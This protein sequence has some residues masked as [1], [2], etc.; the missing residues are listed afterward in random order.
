MR[1]SRAAEIYHGQREAPLCIAYSFRL[2]LA[3][4]GQPKGQAEMRCEK[5]WPVFEWL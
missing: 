1:G 4:I 3:P 5:A 2:L